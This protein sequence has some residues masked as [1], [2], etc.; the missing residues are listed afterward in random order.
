MRQCKHRRCPL[1]CH[2]PGRKR[3]LVLALG[4]NAVF[5]A[6]SA[7][8]TSL[9]G[10]MA[11]RLMAGLGVGGSMPVVFALMSEFCPPSSR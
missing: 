5:G 11:L 7:A 6:L 10:L 4:L 1:P 2:P 3:S 8:A 9:G